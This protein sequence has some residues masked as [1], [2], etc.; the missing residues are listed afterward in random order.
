M[1]VDSP[2]TV[3]T[4]G[5]GLLGTALRRLLPSARFPS[6]SE[7]DVTRADSIGA[8]LDASPP[9]LVIH[10]AA[11]T[12]PPKI[13]QDPSRA[14][15]A[16][17]IGTANIAQWCL[18]HD[19]TLVYISTDYVF[20]GDKGLYRED[21]AMMPVNGYAWSKLGGECAVRLLPDHLVIRT[22]FGPDEFPYPKAFVD[23][24]T[25]RQSVSQTAAQMVRV[26][27]RGAR[28]TVHIGGPRRSVMEYARS[29]DPAKMIEPLSLKDVTFVAPV[30]T[31]LDTTRFRELM[32]DEGGRW[33]PTR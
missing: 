22:S 1:K 10:A 19:A 29:L 15:A 7:L 33:D 26:I 18:D 8:W 28:G 25:S 6:S 31:S 24:W 21:D 23:Q 32:Q 13:D 9:T 3:V 27:E 20:K 14:I 17:I 5:S 30:D 4:G 11:F 16:N 12:S 2:Q